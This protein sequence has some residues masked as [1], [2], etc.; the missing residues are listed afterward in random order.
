MT[1]RVTPGAFLIT[2]DGV[3]PDASGAEVDAG[4]TVTKLPG[5]SGAAVL[6][7]SREGT[8]FAIGTIVM[9][10]GGA[11]S[12]PT[13]G[14]PTWASTCSTPSWSSRRATATVS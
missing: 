1:A 6:I 7:G 11:N 8:H 5:P 13:G 12:R 10:T 4:L 2:K 3:F 9:G 14:R